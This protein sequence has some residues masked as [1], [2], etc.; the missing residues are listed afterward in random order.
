MNNY[1]FNLNNGRGRGPER[2]GDTVARLNLGRTLDGHC[3]PDSWDGTQDTQSRQSPQD[4]SG[5][6][7]SLQLSARSEPAANFEEICVRAYESPVPQHFDGIPSEEWRLWHFVRALTTFRKKLNAKQAF[8]QA[9]AVIRAW[10]RAYRQSGDHWSR[11][12]Y[13]NRDDAEIKFLSAWQR[14]K[15]P[16]GSG[17]MELALSTATERQLVLRPAVMVLRP[18]SYAKFI[19]LA[20]WL[21]VVVGDKP[22]ILPC[23]RTADLLIV[24]PM[25]ISR[26]RE[27]AVEDGYLTFVKEHAFRSAGQSEATEFRFNVSRFRCLVGF[28]SINQALAEKYDQADA[29]EIE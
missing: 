20:G 23:R 24:S 11:Y 4:Q 21:Q 7:K 25:S 28:R 8:Q 13:L 22:I 27:W 5:N 26:L 14:I 12:F 10:S 6:P 19:S 29:T 16:P 9:D 17:P 2:I 15:F 1:S 3:V 18:D